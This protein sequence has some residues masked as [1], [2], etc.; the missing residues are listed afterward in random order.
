MAL[1]DYSDLERE[2]NDAPDPKPL[3]AGT[4]VKL[5]IVRVDSGVIDK[6]ES[7]SDGAGY[8]NVLFDVPSE[9]LCPMFTEFFYDLADRDKIDPSQ[10]QRSLP[11][12]RRFAASFQIDLSKPFNWETD[13]DGREGWAV[14]SYIKDKEGQYPDKNG[15]KEFVVPK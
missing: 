2:I 12:M 13:L 7:K 8:Y 10:F 15:V 9:P 3:P 1:S 14:L 4:E 11:K 6:A 5:R